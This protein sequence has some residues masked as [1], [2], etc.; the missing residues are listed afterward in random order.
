[1]IDRRQFLGLALA[2]LFLGS[3][4][5]AYSQ[6]RLA[7]VGGMLLDG[8]EAPAIHNAAILIEGDRIVA[9]GPAQR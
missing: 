3:A 6:E 1:M 9:V 4:S 2:G 5:A 8:Y 7:L